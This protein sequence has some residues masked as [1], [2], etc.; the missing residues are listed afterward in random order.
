MRE[1]L[2]RISDLVRLLARHAGSGMLAAGKADEFLTRDSQTDGT[3]QDSSGPEALAADLEAMGP[4]YIKLGQLLS[5]RHDLLPEPYTEALSRLQDGVDPVP[6]EDVRRIIADEIGTDVSAL[7]EM[8]DDTPL[9]AAS[10]GQVHRARTRTGKEVVVKVLRPDVREVV[11]DDMELLAQG[12]AL[13][14]NRTSAG[15]RIGTA[16]LLA[17]FRRSLADEL[18]YRKELANLQ[19]FRELVDG[20]ALLV[21]PE[22]VPS[23]STSRVLTMEFIEGR[24]VTDVGPLGLLDV[25]G[26]ALAEAVFR[27]FLNS[28]LSEGLLHADPHPG[29]LLITPEGK[30]AIID[31]GM[32]ARVS[33]G[34]RGQLVRLLLAIGEGD[35]DEAAN[36]LAAMGHPLTDYDAA[37][38]RD[39]V[40]HLVSGAQS[41]G[42]E[43][44]AGSV[45]VSLA[46][47]S[48]AHGL[49]PPAEM[50][51]IGKALL[52]L[53][54]TVAH[55]DPH[56]APA[57]AIRDNV[58]TILK[59]GF[60]VSPAS[61]VASAL[62]A[63]DF[64][65]NLPRR[66][67][68]IMDA[69]SNGELTMRIN[70]LD[71]DRLLETM[72]QVAN[73]LTIGLVLAAV[74]VA[75]ALM[76]RIES[77]PRLLGY[78]LVSLLFFL[79]AAVGG[80]LMV[81]SILISDRRTK[82]RAKQA[83]R[84]APKRLAG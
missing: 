53:D 84:E 71:E 3:D 51:M 70:A 25:D 56:F 14:D 31:L 81:G 63:K 54:Q 20:D 40:S 65:A 66:A 75:A 73:R 62:E 59:S 15:E 7:F 78:P 28:L 69:L 1:K 48:G 46:R 57:D 61:V 72:H 37:A 52:N 5:T 74:T 83:E 21:V 77:G 12:A 47:I 2:T 35:G 38:F 55:L 36:V 22:P 67:N 68:R 13:I 26:H 17:Q 4:T 18:D 27:F 32:V 29:N 44:Q 76:S 10:L 16:A 58:S 60:A 41:L 82:R 11:R 34:V 39:D 23:Y 64:A 42:N 30:L 9:A 19:R 50:S 79:A 80:L 49:R 8:F 6:A 43:L 24:K 33:K 45:L